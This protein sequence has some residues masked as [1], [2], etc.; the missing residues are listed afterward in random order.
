MG[1][2]RRT[3]GQAWTC[4]EGTVLGDGEGKDGGTGREQSSKVSAMK[5]DDDIEL[6]IC[7]A[8]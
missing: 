6:R 7:I 1:G 4:E 3:K 5:T 8:Q 2:T